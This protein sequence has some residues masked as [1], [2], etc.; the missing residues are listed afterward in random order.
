MPE[1]SLVTNTLIQVLVDSQQLRDSPRPDIP[2]IGVSGDL[3]D[4]VRFVKR[5]AMTLLLTPAEIVDDQVD[6]LVPF[7][8]LH[9]VG[10]ADEQSDS[11]RTLVK[12]FVPFENAAFL[13]ASLS[14]DLRLACVRLDQAASTGASLERGRLEAAR[15]F[16]ANAA[17]DILS[18]L[19]LLA[20]TLE[21]EGGT[22]SPK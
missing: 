21:V 17:H 22:P 18:S 2:V 5:T 16:A 6:T 1:P 4:D 13:L 14:T 3:T 20:R 15:Y 10:S 9:L 8:H 11:E 7:I 19:A 12:E